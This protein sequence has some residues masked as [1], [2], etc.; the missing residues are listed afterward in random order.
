MLLDKARQRRNAIAAT[1]VAVSIQHD[2]VITGDRRDR[3]R[4]LRPPAANLNR[5]GDSSRLPIANVRRLAPA[6]YGFTLRVGRENPQASVRERK[7]G[8]EISD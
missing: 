7:R 2:D 5:V 1:G 4:E 6:A 8:C 3:F